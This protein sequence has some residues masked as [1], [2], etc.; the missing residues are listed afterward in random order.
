MLRGDFKQVEYGD[1]FVV[2]VRNTAPTL[3]QRQITGPQML[4]RL[5]P[6]FCD[7]FATTQEWDL[8]LRDRSQALRLDFLDRIAMPSTT[9]FES[10]AFFQKLKASTLGGMGLV[11]REVLK[12][13]V[14]DRLFTPTEAR[15]ILNELGFYHRPPV[16]PIQNAFQQLGQSSSTSHA[17]VVVRE[18]IDDLDSVPVANITPETLSTLHELRHQR[19]LRQFQ[20]IFFLF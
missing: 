18:L 7:Q 15:L 6:P 12:Y 20:G 9:T 13:H 1:V 5:P 10:P 16:D 14:V 17:H 8:D 2:R 19:H 11:N 3:W 4:C